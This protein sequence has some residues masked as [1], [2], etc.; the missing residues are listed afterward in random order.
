[1]KSTGDGQR[2]HNSMAGLVMFHR[3]KRTL[4]FSCWFSP[5]IYHLAELMLHHRPARSG[6]PETKKGNQTT[7]LDCWKE[8]T[9]KF[10]ISQR[11]QLS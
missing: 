1:M 7:C 10:L 9:K 11:I 5:S 6:S 8:F 2:K 3:P 4:S